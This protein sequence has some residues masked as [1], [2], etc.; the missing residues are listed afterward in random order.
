MHIGHLKGAID[1]AAVGDYEESYALFS[2]AYQHMVATGDTL[3]MAIAE[4]NPEMFA[5]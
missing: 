1:A 3:A 4:Q 2:E 5:R